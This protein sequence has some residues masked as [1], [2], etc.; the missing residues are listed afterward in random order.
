MK[1]FIVSHYMLVHITW[2]HIASAAANVWMR[3]KHSDLRTDS[4]WG[5]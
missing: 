4:G 3:F 5:G 2:I 1:K